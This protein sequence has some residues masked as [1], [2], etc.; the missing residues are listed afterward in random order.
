[1]KILAVISNFGTANNKFL[2]VVLRELRSMTHHV[3]TVVLSDIP[4]DL[5]PDV[6]VRVGLP[7]KDPW[8]LPFAHK[9]V[10]AENLNDYDLFIYNEDDIRLTEAHVSAF[11]EATKVLHDDEIAGFMRYELDSEGNRYFCDVRQH[12]RWDPRYTRR[13]GGK[14]FGF[15]TN[16]HA[17]CFLLTQDQLRR[18]IASGG[19]LVAPHRGRYG[20]PESAATD[21]YTQ[22]GFRKMISLTN[23]EDFIVHHLSNKYVGNVGIGNNDMHKQIQI[24]MS[25][26]GDLR[27]DGPLFEV[28]SKTLHSR[29]SKSYYE[30]Y[31]PELVSLIPQTA[32]SVL[33]IGCG[34]GATE[35]ALQQSQK[36]VTAIPLDSVIAPLAEARG[37]RVVQGTFE[38]ARTKLQGETFD[39]LLFSHE[40]HL[41]TDPVAVLRDFAPLLG[42]HGYVVAS[43]PNLAQASVAYRRATGNPDYQNLSSYETAG[44]H[45]T[46]RRTVESWFAQSGFR[47]EQ[48]IYEIPE[49]VKFA[50]RLSLG[51]ASSLLGSK[52]NVRASKN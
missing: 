48:A 36:S 2:Q 24:L 1:M 42:A 18:A 13:R 8:T 33:S 50:D 10:F 45:L 46:S 49:N 15:F 17:G 27:S 38:S 19:F 20:L 30:P 28:E 23:F 39:C 4:K 29:C 41:F 21:P 44:F 35:V 31:R 32:R 40:L 11:L 52:M 51:M 47:L 16:E 7:S 12:F 22:C 43:V 14:V 9:Q 26:D 6:K 37:L 34:W 3:D 25:G 5:G